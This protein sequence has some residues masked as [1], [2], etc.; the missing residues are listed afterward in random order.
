MFTSVAHLWK[1]EG[2]TS[3]QY[4]PLWTSSYEKSTSGQMPSTNRN[5]RT[6]NSSLGGSLLSP[7]FLRVVLDPFLLGR[8]LNL[9][10][11]FQL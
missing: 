5:D 2:G 3:C 11:T 9:R 7:V 8:S 4:V 10:T 1:S 6:P